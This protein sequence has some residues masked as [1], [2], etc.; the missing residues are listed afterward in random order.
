MLPPHAQ[1]GKRS[2]SASTVSTTPGALRRRT[3]GDRGVES[4]DPRRL[5]AQVEGAIGEAVCTAQRDE[6]PPTSTLG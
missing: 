2:M 6:F 3:G 1:P 5:H 4:G